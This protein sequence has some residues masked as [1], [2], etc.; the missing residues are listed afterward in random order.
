MRSLPLMSLVPAA[1][2]LLTLTACGS[3]D[4]DT[5]AAAPV[6]KPSFAAG[7][8]MAD[9]AAAGKITVGTKFDQPL[10]GLKGLSGKPEGF[11]VEIAKIIAAKMG[12]A[13]DKITFVESVS[14]NRE[15]FLEQG[16]VDMVVATYTINDKRD[17]KVDFA[18]PYFVA[19]QDIL[20]AKGN[21]KNITGPESLKGKKTCSVSGATPAATMQEK[22][23]LT[24]TELVLV[25]AYSKCRDALANGQIDALTTDNV[26]L[27]GYVSEAPDKFE[28]IGKP[29]SQEPY[30]IGVPEGQ[31]PFCE[32]INKTLKEAVA[33]GSYEKAYKETAGKIIETVPALPEPR[34]CD[35]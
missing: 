12:I 23:G 31:E 27:S 16:K 32:F 17:K 11:D 33:D 8:R 28:L 15:P 7:T 5:G 30:G 6:D 25:D 20:V 26:I 13:A 2:M 34:G 3:G 1:A 9:I 24:T 22:Y 10:F 14:A 35:K 4:D 18:G 21:P 19:G 29:F